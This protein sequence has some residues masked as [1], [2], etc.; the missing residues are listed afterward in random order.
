MIKQNWEYQSKKDLAF[1]AVE[2]EDLYLQLKQQLNDS[3]KYEETFGHRVGHEPLPSAGISDS[4]ENAY[5][6]TGEPTSERMAEHFSEKV[7]PF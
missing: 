2:Q 1:L 3:G 6:I 4:W 5:I 7:L